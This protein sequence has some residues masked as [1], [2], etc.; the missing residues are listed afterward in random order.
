MNLGEKP[1]GECEGCRG[2][3][4]EHR[5]IT[6]ALNEAWEI[7]MRVLKSEVIPLGFL[8]EGH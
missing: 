1:G 7:L 5:S 6:H 3:Q 4:R 8:S 2:D